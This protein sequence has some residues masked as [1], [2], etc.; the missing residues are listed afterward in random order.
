MEEACKQ[1]MFLLERGLIEPSVSPY[2]ASLLLFG[3]LLATSKGTLHS[4]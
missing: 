3:P 1:V 2:G 4:L